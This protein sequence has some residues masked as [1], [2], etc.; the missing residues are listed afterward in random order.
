VYGPLLTGLLEKEPED[1]KGICGLRV[2]RTPIAFCHFN[3]SF[4]NGNPLLIFSLFYQLVYLLI[5][6]LEIIILRKRSRTC[7]NP[8]AKCEEYQR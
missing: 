7:E 2:L 1:K 4:L 6:R 5:Q 3:H 8:E